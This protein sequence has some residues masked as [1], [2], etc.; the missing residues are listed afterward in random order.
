M[1]KTLL[2]LLVYF[3]D[4]RN[5]VEPFCC[6]LDCPTFGQEQTVFFSPYYLLPS[7]VSK[8]LKYHR[9]DLAV[10]GEIIPHE[11]KQ[12]SQRTNRKF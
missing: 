9:T 1:E 12:K 7:D 5:E 10:N 4:F 3:G 8:S 11:M 2:F 6:S